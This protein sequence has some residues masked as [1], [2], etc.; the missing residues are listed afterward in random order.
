MVLLGAL[1]NGIEAFVGGVLGVILHRFIKKDMGD[2]LLV[3]QGLCVV[4]IAVQGMVQGGS[5]IMVTIA[6]ALGA[7]LGYVLDIDAWFHRVGDAV[8]MRLDKRFSGNAK[9]GNFSAGFVPASILICTGSMAIV[10]S[11]QSG[12]QLDHSTLLSKGTI[13]LIVCMV[14]AA[15]L[16]VGVAFSG[17]T[18]FL[19]EG[20]LTL[21]STA[22]AP[23]LSDIVVE[24]M[25]VT[26]SLLLL[27]IGL[28][29]MG[30]TNIKAANLIPACFMPVLLVPLFE[31]FGLV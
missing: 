18:V 17:V 31:L 27:A 29:L 25:V 10:G 28:N 14:M 24:N 26:G 12:I 8:Q 4:L 3:G 22:I 13:D 9:L 16:G 30:V 19:Y 7:A 6:M 1:V 21:L 2:M 5:V 20:L 23:L 15:S 11:L